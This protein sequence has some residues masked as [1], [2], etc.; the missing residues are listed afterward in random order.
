MY[1]DEPDPQ[2]PSITSAIER[3]FTTSQRVLVDRIDLLRLEAREDL[4]TAAR[5]TV[6]TAGAALL[7]FYGWIV[8]LA[9]VVYLLWGSL[10]LG[11][12]LLAVTAFH[13]IGGV[14]LGWAGV[15][16]LGGIRVLRPDDP[17]ADRRERQALS[18]GM[19]GAT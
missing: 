7:F 1:M 2:P 19:R 14:V 6:L 4:F 8:A 5:G 12:A 15:R 9:W 17:E 3:V 10:P 11:T 18:T 16:T 13:V